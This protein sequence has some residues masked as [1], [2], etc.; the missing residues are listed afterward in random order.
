MNKRGV[1]RKKRA[2]TRKN[3]VEIPDDLHFEFSKANDSS[4]P[5]ESD[6]DD[7]DVAAQS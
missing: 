2:L 6:K 1:N 4:I 5:N 3:A 7:K